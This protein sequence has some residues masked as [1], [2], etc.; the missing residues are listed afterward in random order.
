ML[1]QFVSFSDNKLVKYLLQLVQALKF[2]PY[3]DCP[4]AE[5]LLRRG[6][7]N[8]YVG[9]YLFWHMRFVW[10]TVVVRFNCYYN[11]HRAEMHVPGVA[12]IYGLMLEAFCRGCGQYRASLAKQVQLLFIIIIVY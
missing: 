2:E 8:R 9:H 7:A 12:V 6:L 4:L 10:N 3:L 1:F 5:F 11:Y